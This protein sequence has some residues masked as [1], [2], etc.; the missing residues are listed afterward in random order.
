[1]ETKG[2]IFFSSSAVLSIVSEILSALG[3][4]VGGNDGVVGNLGFD[5]ALT[6]PVFLSGAHN[7]Q[8]VVLEWHND[9][10]RRPPAH[11]TGVVVGVDES[12]TAR[13]ARQNGR[14]LL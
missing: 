14:Q 6:Y 2:V 11:Q 13:G 4:K 10:A 12:E 8:S 5:Y 9:R 3:D 1:M 7:G